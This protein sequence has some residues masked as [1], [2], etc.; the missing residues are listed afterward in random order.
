MAPSV[1]QT[2][3]RGANGWRRRTPCTG[4]SVAQKQAKYFGH[5]LRQRFL[6]L[7][8][9][10]CRISKI[11]LAVVTRGIDVPGL[12]RVS[13]TSGVSD[14]RPPP[15]GFRWCG[16]R[17]EAALAL[18]GEHPA[19][20][21]EMVSQSSP[22]AAGL[23]DKGVGVAGHIGRLGVDGLLVVPHQKRQ[24]AERSRPPHQED[25]FAQDLIDSKAM[26]L[27]F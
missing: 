18:T 11:T 26:S 19:S 23:C 10:E 27:T 6:L 24:G 21:P 4:T 20:P 7:G 22:L 12:L 15:S 8:Q 13:T 2:L 17:K 16:C 9:M 25:P 5:S 1:K 3:P 14:R